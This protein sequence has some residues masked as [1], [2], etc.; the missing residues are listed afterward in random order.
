MSHRSIKASFRILALAAGL[1]PAVGARAQE[2]LV[3]L[4]LTPAQIAEISRLVDQEAS[5]T[6]IT[7]PSPA[8]W[9]LQLQIQEALA[10]DPAASRAVLLA[11]EA[12]R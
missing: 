6:F 5:R 3:M 10:A 2:Q 11:I 4:K 12:A 7:S 1:L 9:T 8:Y